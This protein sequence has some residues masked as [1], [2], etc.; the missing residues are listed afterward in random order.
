MSFHTVA[1]TD[2]IKPTPGFSRYGT[3]KQFVAAHQ[4]SDQRR[5][6][7]EQRFAKVHFSADAAVDLLV[8]RR[9]RLGAIVDMR[10]VHEPGDGDIERQADDAFGGPQRN[11]FETKILER[12]GHDFVDEPGAVDQGTVTIEKSEFHQ[13]SASSALAMSKPIR[14]QLWTICCGIGAVTIRRPPSGW[15]TSM[16]RACRCSLF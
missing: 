6:A 9:H 5:D 4:G 7:V 15:G 13:S 8:M 10:L 1:C 12:A 11:A 3:Q 2:L 14:F 16:R